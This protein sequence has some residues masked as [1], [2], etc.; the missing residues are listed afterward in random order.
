MDEYDMLDELKVS[1]PKF[2]LELDT[3][4]NI[5][6]KL[7]KTLNW[8]L[9]DDHI[10]QFNY[11]KTLRCFAELVNTDSA[12]FYIYK[13]D[14]LQQIYIYHCEY[15]WSIKDI[16]NSKLCDVNSNN[17][18]ILYDH[19]VSGKIFNMSIDSLSTVD[20]DIFNMFNIK[21]MLAIP[22]SLMNCSNYGFVSFIDYTK[23]HTWSE[24]EIS[25]LN[26]VASIIGTISYINE[27]KEHKER[28]LL[29]AIKDLKTIKA[30]IDQTNK[31]IE[32]K[33]NIK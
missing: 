17:L 9:H 20:Q 12:F 21:S 24:L 16:N 25:A 8:L 27:I 28:Q 13:H 30:D 1:I 31:L 3:A 5:L 32:A 7:V 2:N 29:N 18:P 6:F 19:V 10:S 15:F 4:N 33:R 11:T 26:A 22:I 23:Y 14:K